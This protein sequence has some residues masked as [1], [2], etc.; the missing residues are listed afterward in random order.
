MNAGVFYNSFR[1]SKRHHEWQ[2][3]DKQQVLFKYIPA[4][5]KDYCTNS[6]NTC[7]GS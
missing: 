4:C 7:A 2:T 3:I 6:N 1:F 5:K